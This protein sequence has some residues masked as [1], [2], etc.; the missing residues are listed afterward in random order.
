MVGMDDTTVKISL[1][2]NLSYANLI[3]NRE[4]IRHIQNVKNYRVRGK[5]K[6]L[7]MYGFN[8][9]KEDRQNSNLNKI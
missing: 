5:S 6:T 4:I 3:E 9:L 2:V 7:N 8:L 1:L